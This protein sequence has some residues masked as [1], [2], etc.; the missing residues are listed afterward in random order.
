MFI[1]GNVKHLSATTVRRY[2]NKY[3]KVSNTKNIT[4]HGFR[5]SHVSFLVYIGCDTQEIA[6]RIGDTINTVEHTYYHMFPGKKSKTIPAINKF[7][8]ENTN[9]LRGN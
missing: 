1:F 4:L 9:K 2:L 7:N 5:H 3:I 8:K 6:E